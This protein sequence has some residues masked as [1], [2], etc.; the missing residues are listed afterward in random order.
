MDINGSKATF[1]MNFSIDKTTNK[2]FKTSRAR[3]QLVSGSRSWRWLIYCI[4]LLFMVNKFM[5]SEVKAAG[6][7]RLL[8]DTV[9]KNE[10]TS[11]SPRVSLGQRL[12]SSSLQNFGR[13]QVQKLGRVQLKY[14]TEAAKFISGVILIKQGLC[15]SSLECNYGL[16]G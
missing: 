10:M 15:S 8:G 11:D 14:C 1:V 12:L 3:E 6:F 16:L 13:P 2:H 9:G 7:S 5:I 4:L